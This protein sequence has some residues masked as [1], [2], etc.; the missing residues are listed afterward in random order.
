MIKFQGKYEEYSYRV[1]NLEIDPSVV[2]LIEGQWVTKT[3]GKV[4]IADGTKKS[5]L[6]ITSMRTGRDQLSGKAEKLVAFL[7]G[8]FF[9]IQVDQFDATKTYVEFT[10]LKVVA[11]GQLSPWIS[12]TDSAAL[13]V[14]YSTGAPVNG[15]LSICSA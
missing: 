11:N 10:P 9:D 6:C 5:F 1:S 15:F 13:L 2:S 8:A 12:G 7:H 4:T 3:N 14:A